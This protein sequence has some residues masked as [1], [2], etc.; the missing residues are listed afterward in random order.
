GT[1]GRR[2]CSRTSRARPR[3]WRRRPPRCCASTRLAESVLGPLAASSRSTRWPG[4]RC[5][6]EAAGGGGAALL[7]AAALRHPL[8][9]PHR[10]AAGVLLLGRLA[11]Q[12]RGQLREPADGRRGRELWRRLHAADVHDLGVDRRGAAQAAHVHAAH[13]VEEG[14]GRAAADGERAPRGRAGARAAAQRQRRRRRPGPGLRDGAAAGADLQGHELPARALRR[15]RGL[16]CTDAA[17]GGGVAELRGGAAQRGLRGAG[18]GLRA[19]HRPQVPRRLARPAVPGPQ[20]L[21]RAHG[22]PVR[23]GGAG[24]QRHGVR[25]ARV[26]APRAGGRPR[27]GGRAGLLGAR[28]LPARPLVGKGALRRRPGR[29]TSSPTSPTSAPVI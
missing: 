22:V 23:E 27:L 12:Q 17:R 13:H 5:G 3:W 19:R 14:G 2:R 11:H 25:R 18:P 26:P 4:E 15:D 29:W 9:G 21:H 1:L 7:H 10:R 20:G 24:P 16:R 28:L 8:R 6:P